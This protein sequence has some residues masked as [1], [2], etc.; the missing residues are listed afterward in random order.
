MNGFH[1]RYAGKSTRTSH[2]RAGGASM[3]IIVAIVH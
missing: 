3:S 1:S 2:T